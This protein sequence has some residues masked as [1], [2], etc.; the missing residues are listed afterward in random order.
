MSAEIT[1]AIS[2]QRESERERERGR[3]REKERK[4][5]KELKREFP[6]APF[7]K[8]SIVIDTKAPVKPSRPLYWGWNFRVRVW[9]LGAQGFGAHTEDLYSNRE[10][11][12]EC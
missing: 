10:D 8:S 12:I 3:E 6:G 2:R 11:A 4:K 1:T 9:G 7:S 5:K